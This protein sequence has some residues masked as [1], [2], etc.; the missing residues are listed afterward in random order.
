M[1]G[2]PLRYFLVF[3]GIFWMTERTMSTS[4]HVRRQQS[5]RRIPVY[6]AMAKRTL[7]SNPCR[8]ATSMSRASSST[9][10]SRRVCESSARI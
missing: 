4:D 9:V 10:S 2:R 8:E 3:A 5:P 1:I 6:M 7:H